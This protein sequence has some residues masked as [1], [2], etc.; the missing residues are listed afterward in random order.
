MGQCGGERKKKRVR[1]DMTARGLRVGLRETTHTKCLIRVKSS[2]VSVCNAERSK[3][4]NS[5]CVS[6][7]G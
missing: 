2:S 6:N 5:Y 7:K 1:E 4:C 3:V